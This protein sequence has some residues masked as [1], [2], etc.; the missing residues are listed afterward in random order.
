MKKRVFILFAIVAVVLAGCASAPPQ[1]AATAPAPVPV[2]NVIIMLTDGTGPEAWP[3][4]RWV[5]GS[6]LTVDE[7]LTGAI[8]TYGADSVITDSAPGATAYATGYK[9]GDKGISVGAWNVTIDAARSNVA[10]AYVPVATLIE[11]AKLSGR[12]VGLIATSNVQHA[13]PAAFSAHWH[14]R[15]NYN[16]LGEQQV[17]QGMDVVLSGGLQYLLPKEV[18]GGRREDHENLV[19]VLTARGYSIVK[20]RD[21]MLAATSGKLWGAF[22]PDS[23]AYDIDRAQLA[24]G[25][26]SLAEMT[27]KA[28]QLLSGGAKGKSGGFFLFVEGSKVDWGA[29]DNDPSELVSDLLA[30]DNAVKVALDFAKKNGETL[31]VVVSDHGTG[32]ITIGTASDKN[33]TQTDDD[34]VVAPMRAAKVTTE[35]LGKILAGDSS[36]ENIKKVFAEQWGMSDL[37]ADD[38]KALQTAMNAKSSITGIAAGILSKRA[39]LGWTTGNHTGA[40]LFLFSYGPDRPTGLWQNTDIGRLCA[41][42]MGFDFESLNA[43]LFVEAVS[44]FAAVGLEATLDKTDPAN[45]VLVVTKGTAKVEFPLSKNILIHDGKATELEGIVV[46]AEKLGKVYLPKQAVTLAVADL[47]N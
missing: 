43:R 14:D 46:Q 44:S 41:K 34:S 4:A 24:P 25:Q 10:P 35:G 20:T 13:T 8:R 31:L 5:K 18:T 40:D 7:I 33:Y 15:G 6:P 26:P 42:E 9:S 17:Y 1:V 47:Q 37:T 3:L 12:A 28:I 36:E 16:E 21:E 27:D 29:H 30:F 22:A 45:P 32:G 19:D 23:M 39:R 38:L 11:G 2:K